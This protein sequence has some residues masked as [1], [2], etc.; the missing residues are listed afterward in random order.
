MSVTVDFY[1]G[2][3]SR[4]SYLASTQ[5]ARLEKET[6]AQFRWHPLQSHALIASNGAD[7]FSGPPVSG[8]YDW[9]YRKRDAEDWAAYYG[10][11]FRD[12]VG[13]LDYSADLPAR[14]AHAAGRQDRMVPMCHALFRLIFADDRSHFG[15]QDVADE[16][17]RLGLDMAAFEADLSDPALAE[18]LLAEAAEAGRRGAFGVP[19]FFVGERM[20]WGNDR[21]VLLEA[22]LNGLPSA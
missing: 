11:P 16:A 13:R 4:Y 15:Q 22:V 21:L 5:I 20:F 6:G 3:G 18:A 2:L 14:A 8:Q 9:G 19:T 7:P 10:V 1:L 12:P 17:R